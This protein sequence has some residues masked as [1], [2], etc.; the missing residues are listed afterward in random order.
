MVVTEVEMMMEI[1]DQQYSNA[2]ASILVTV[3]GT[4][5]YTRVPQYEKALAAIAISL[6][7]SASTAL[8]PHEEQP[9]Q[10]K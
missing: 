2:A 8:A 7:G 9:L 5:T 10:G 3:D 4:R 1:R 6:F